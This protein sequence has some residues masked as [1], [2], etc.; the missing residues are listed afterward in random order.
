MVYIHVY[1][2][3]FVII[4][5]IHN[6]HVASSHYGSSLISSGMINSTKKALYLFCASFSVNSREILSCLS[7]ELS[8]LAI[9]FSPLNPSSQWSRPTALEHSLV[10][11]TGELEVGNFT[12]N[13]E[14]SLPFALPFPP[15]ISFREVTG[16]L[17]WLCV[18]KGIFSSARLCSDSL[19]Q[20][21]FSFWMSCTYAEGM[22]EA[23]G[24][25]YSSGHIM[26]HSTVIT[27][28]GLGWSARQPK[29]PT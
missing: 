29:N 13:D 6:V 1:V 3:G 21:L 15:A 22:V 24:S 12:S 5:P 4:I 17:G 7:S 14:T 26:S 20:S 11:G 16:L 2:P 27:H 9:V 28:S 19:F 18:T 10:V 25:V 23:A 8:I